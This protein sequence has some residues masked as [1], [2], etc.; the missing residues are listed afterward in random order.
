MNLHDWSGVSDAI[1]FVPGI[2]YLLI[3]ELRRRGWFHRPQFRITPAGLSAPVLLRSEP[4]SDSAVFEQ[5]FIEREYESVVQIANPRLILDLGAN[6]GLSSLY[7]TR[8]FPDAEIVAL[9]PDPQN[10]PL[11]QRN[12]A[13]YSRIKPILGA[14]WHSPGSLRL[15]PG[16]YR[17]RREWAT[18]VVE[19]AGDV[20]AFDI[21]S[22][23]GSRAID[24]LKIDIERSEIPLFSKNTG[25]LSQVRNL[26][27]ELHDQECVDAFFKAME[28][29][30]YDLSYS[31]E[32]TVCRSMRQKAPCT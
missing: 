9:E 19:G 28:P 29:L 14:V 21:P 1:G 6:I 20:R 25:W 10:F 18:Q 32:L 30:D 24:L 16:T 12:T 4:S 11:L 23:A 2:R 17:D 15:S 31:G 13:V 26:C 3:Q 5:V 7:F 8:R 22:L 27:I